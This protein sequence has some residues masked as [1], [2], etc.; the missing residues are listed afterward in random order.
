MRT[1]DLTIK[2][3][4]TDLNFLCEF[5]AGQVIGATKYVPNKEIS[6]IASANF[7]KVYKELSIEDKI[8]VRGII[9]ETEANPNEALKEFIDNLEELGS[10]FFNK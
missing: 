1:I 9:K 8:R 7:R 5:F 10:I 4:K 3:T 6:K 2:V